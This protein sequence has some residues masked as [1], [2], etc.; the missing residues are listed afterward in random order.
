MGKVIDLGS[1][2]PD[3]PIYSGGPMVSFR[4]PL[5][6]SSA[7]TATNTGGAQHPVQQPNEPHPR[8]GKE[9][10]FYRTAGHN[11]G[12]VFASESRAKYVARLH[13]AL[14]TSRTWAQFRAAVPPREYSDIIR[15]FDD[16]GEPRPRSTDSFSADSVPGWS[17]G[18]YP[19]WLQKEMEHVVP[20]D[21]LEAYGT[22]ERT[23]INGG[24]WHLP[25]GRASDIVKALEGHGFIVREALDLV[26][27]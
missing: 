23:S 18:D 21:I 10:L 7:D 3:D 5:T 27:S 6:P 8:G 12:L 4:P 14:R 9:T 13:Q 11:G 1:A 20:M 19:P 2:K 15:S 22:L 26:F 16:F 17:D 25:A 24:Y